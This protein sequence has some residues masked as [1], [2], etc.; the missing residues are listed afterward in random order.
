MQKI[1]NAATANGDSL[2]VTHNGGE[3]EIVVDGVFGGATVTLYA[4]Y[5]EAGVYVPIYEG[6][7]TES[8]IRVLRTIRKCTLRLTITDAS[9]TTEIN[10]WI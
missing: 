3:V 8:S 1:F 7:W 10:A 4:L 2:T 9:E 6:A 5:A